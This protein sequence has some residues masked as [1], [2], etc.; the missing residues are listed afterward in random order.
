MKNYF[1]PRS[2]LKNIVSIAFNFVVNMVYIMTEATLVEQAKGKE[3]GYSVSHGKLRT[4]QILLVLV[5]FIRYYG[6]EVE[7]FVFL[8]IEYE[9]VL[10]SA[11]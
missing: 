1:K 4:R 5:V 11:P 2:A 10:F 9:T 8:T 7:M 6:T 3:L